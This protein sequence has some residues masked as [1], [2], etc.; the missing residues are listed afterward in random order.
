M[1]IPSLS[2]EHKEKDM[3]ISQ[4]KA[5]IFELEQRDRDY[6]ELNKKFRKIQNENILLN[7]TKM[8]LEYSLKQREENNYEQ[9]QNLRNDCENLKINLNEKVAINKKLFSENETLQKQIEI[10]NKEICKLNNNLNDLLNQIEK[11]NEDK[12][13]LEKIINTLGEIKSNQKKEIAKLI[14]DNTKLAKTLKQ[15]EN[16]IK[17]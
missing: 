4:L 14:D 2:L 12:K 13:G 3:L 7:E 5:H 10:Q 9:I 17:I 8:Q 16:N 15:N 6:E 11:I 1:N